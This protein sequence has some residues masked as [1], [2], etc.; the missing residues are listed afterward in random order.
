MDYII[1]AVEGLQMDY[2]V[3]GSKTCAYLSKDTQIDVLRMI[4]Q[5]GN[6]NVNQEDLIFNITA[7]IS[8]SFPDALYKCYFLPNSAMQSWTSHYETFNS[9]K[10]FQGAFV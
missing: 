6:P 4:A 10:D 9:F 3:P 7:T 1:S 5:I 2:Y 8:K